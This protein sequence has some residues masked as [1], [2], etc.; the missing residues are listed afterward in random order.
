MDH[1]HSHAAP[2]ASEPESAAA[3]AVPA[4]NM[5]EAEAEI[6]RRE[7]LNKKLEAQKAAAASKKRKKFV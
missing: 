3:P 7:A 6:A 5:T 2:I 4:P 1:K